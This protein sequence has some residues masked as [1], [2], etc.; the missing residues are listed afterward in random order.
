MNKNRI[1]N[2]VMETPGNT[3]PAVLSTLL[4]ENNSNKFF[5]TLTLTSDSG[6]TMDKSNAEITEAFNA[7]KTIY[8][9]INFNGI[10]C[11]VQ[12]T[13]SAA[14]EGFQYPSFNAYGIDTSGTTIINLYV[15]P[16]DEESYAFTMNAVE[17]GGGSVE[18]ET[19]V[20]KLFGVGGDTPYIDKTY[21]EI[22]EAYNAGKLILLRDSV[23]AANGL[24]NYQGGTNADFVTYWFNTSGGGTSYT[25][26]KYDI[27]ISSQDSVSVNRTKIVD[28]TT[29]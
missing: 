23:S 3:N 12:A 27:H 29:T 26:Y 21:A 10:D 13:L 17:I 6:G 22:N 2:Y 14:F 1:I 20:V 8:F 5:V 16:S 28:Y 4:D 18:D 19:F 7:D 11:V 9:A 25:L 24:I 15:D